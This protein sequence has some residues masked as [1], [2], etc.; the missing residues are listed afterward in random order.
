[1]TKRGQ[2]RTAEER[3]KLPSNIRPPEPLTVQ[4]GIGGKP[5]P[6]AR[7]ASRQ[8]WKDRPTETGTTSAPPPPQ[9]PPRTASTG[10]FFRNNSKG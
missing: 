8:G 2:K 5:A 6:D 7:P 3:S 1:M 9:P 10:L 4:T